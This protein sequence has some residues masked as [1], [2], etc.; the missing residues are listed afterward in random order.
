MF[1]QTK[2]PEELEQLMEAVTDR[3]ETA[4]ST[5]DLSA[6]R[7]GLRHSMERIRESLAVPAPADGCPDTGKTENINMN[8]VEIDTCE[9]N[10]LLF[11]VVLRQYSAS[12]L[13]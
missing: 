3:M 4:A 1:L 2:Q 5:A 8:K 7:Q 12:L 13:T 10:L 11:K 9:V 6:A